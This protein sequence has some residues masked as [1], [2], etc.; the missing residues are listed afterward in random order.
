MTSWFCNRMTI[1]ILLHFFCLFNCDAGIKVG[2]GKSDITPPLGTPSAGMGGRFGKGMVGVHDPLLVI[3]GH[4]ND[5]HR[6]IVLPE[7]WRVKVFI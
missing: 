1:F 6:Y 3:F 2:I 4:T 7:V 5:A